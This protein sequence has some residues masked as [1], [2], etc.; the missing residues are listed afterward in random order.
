MQLD[1]MIARNLAHA[2]LSV[3]WG[4]TALE[5]AAA[6]TLP[7][8]RRHVRRGIVREL[9]GLHRRS[10]RVYPPDVAW[11]VDHLLESRRFALA[12]IPIERGDHDW[13][14]SLAA[15]CF[16]PA[17]GL[18]G[19]DLPHLE[20]PAALAQWLDLS[21][22]Q[23]DWMA[24]V[25]RQ[26]S[27][28]RIPILQHYRFHIVPKRS[29]HPRLIEEPKPRLKSVQTRILHSIMDKLPAHPAAYGFVAGRSCVEG[30]AKH[31]GERVLL[32]ADIADFFATTPVRR[33][34]AT[35]RSLGYPHSVARLLTGLTTTV[36]PI[37]VLTRLRREWD[38]PPD[39]ADVFGVRHVPQGAPTSPALANLAA[40]ALDR[41]LS[42]LAD[43][44][45]ATYTRYSDDL[46]FSGGD[47]L[48][49]NADWFLWIV[50][51]IARDEGYAINAAKTRIAPAGSRQRVTGIVVNRH[52][53]VARD[54]FDRL[55]ATLHNAVRFG[56]ATQNRD[57]H[58][59]FRA[60]LTG[61]V[62]WVEQVNP[63]RGAKLRRLL[64]Q[65][66]WD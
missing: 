4:A 61:R 10:G 13:K 9:I 2:L 32:T 51:E 54:D 16:S 8:T 66:R 31:A 22:D 18:T 19:L 30:A 63:V 27:I 40:N 5:G 59:D 41:R 62:G 20:T 14:V 52:A 42:G 33:V 23:L 43:R 15:A 47:G 26:S 50:A 56:P 25:R 44:Y 1:E 29:G 58:P 34:H 3:E 36:T 49:R 17:P 7:D 55:K 28:T 53:N 48:R 37:S 60:H 57:A 65:V 46:A 35:F 24:D 38:A 11:I 64:E 21:L 45:G 6:Q 12:V 39:L